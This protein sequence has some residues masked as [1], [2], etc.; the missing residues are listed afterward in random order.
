MTTA[1]SV[2]SHNVSLSLTDRWLDLFHGL[3]CGSVSTANP[4]LRTKYIG[5]HMKPSQGEARA[6]PKL[7]VCT[8]LTALTAFQPIPP[9]PTIFY[10]VG[11]RIS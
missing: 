6:R 7:S 3:L 4:G 9:A 2:T 10:V 1:Y 11:L 8:Q 5:F